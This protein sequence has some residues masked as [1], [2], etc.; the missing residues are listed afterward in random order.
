M[1]QSTNIA[2]RIATQSD[3]VCLSV[4]ATQIF[5]DTYATHGINSDLANE[6]L[7]QYSSEVFVARLGDPRI[8]IHVAESEGN[9]IGLIDIEFDSTCPIKNIS[10]PEVLRLYVQAPFQRRGVGRALLNYAEYR[11][12]SLRAPSI[13]LTAWVGNAGAL[14]F[15]PCVGYKDAGVTQYVINGK[16]YENRVFVKAIA[17]AA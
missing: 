17:G 14:A 1:P 9:L 15:Y 13:W 7:E 12:Q 8:E 6:A 3:A 5:L 11:A 2:I 16:E 4:L 10:G